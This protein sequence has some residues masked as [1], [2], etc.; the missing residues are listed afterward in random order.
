MFLSTNFNAHDSYGLVPI[1]CLFFSLENVFS[2]FIACLIILHWMDGR[3]CEFHLAVAGTVFVFLQIFLGFVIGQ[4]KRYLE[5]VWSFWVFPL[6]FVTWVCSSVQGRANFPLLLGQDI[7]EYSIQCS[8]NHEF[9]QFGQYEQAL[10]PALCEH[11][12][13][14]LSLASSSFPTYVHWSKILYQ[15]TPGEPSADLKDSLPMQQ[16]SLWDSVYKQ[17][18]LVQFHLHSSEFA[19]LHLDSLFIN[20]NSFQAES[21]NNQKSHF[22]CF[23]SLGDH[24]IHHLLTSVLKTI[25]SHL[26]HC[27]K[28][29]CFITKF[30]AYTISCQSLHG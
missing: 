16:P 22:I 9:L 27:I 23:P 2:C 4:I 25:V 29:K 11:G 12:A 17:A 3:C 1:D 21:W 28:P 15:N 30:S 26:M 19:G 13:L 14:F 6:W 24:V 8:T 18:A 10:F 20:G 7:F 5:T